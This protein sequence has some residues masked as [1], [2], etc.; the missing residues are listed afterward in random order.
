M[1]YINTEHAHDP[2]TDIHLMKLQLSILVDIKKVEDLIWT[3]VEL[4]SQLFLTLL[5][6]Q[7]ALH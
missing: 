5:H 3:E 1:S 7:L 4:L 2:Q 6:H